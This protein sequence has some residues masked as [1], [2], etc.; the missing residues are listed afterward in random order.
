MKDKGRAKK[1][2]ALLTEGDMRE[3]KIGEV[4]SVPPP[5][6]PH[7]FSFVCAPVLAAPL[8]DNCNAW[9]RLLFKS[10]CYHYGPGSTRKH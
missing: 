9:N 3:R 6:P 10:Y 5:S 1:K 2:V 8:P 4:T 7:F